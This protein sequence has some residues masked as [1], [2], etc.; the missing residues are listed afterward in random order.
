[1]AVSAAACFLSDQSFGL[2]R[3]GCRAAECTARHFQCAAHAIHSGE[4]HL[5]LGLMSVRQ[6]YAVG[7]RVANLKGAISPY[8]LHTYLAPLPLRHHTADHRSA[9][10]AGTKSRGV[11]VCAAQR[12]SGSFKNT[13][14]SRSRLVKDELPAI[15]SEL[16]PT[17]NSNLDT[18]KLVCGS[19]KT[20]WWL[21]RNEDGRPDGCQHKHAWQ[22]RII[23]RCRHHDP[24]GCP[25]C[26]GERVCPCNSLAAGQFPALMHC[27]DSERTAWWLDPTQLSPRSSVEVCWRHDCGDGKVHHWSASVCSVVDAYRADGQLPCPGCRRVRRE[28][29][30]LLKDELPDIYAELHPTKNSDIDTEKLTCGSSKRVWWLCKSDKRRP[31]GCQHEHAWETQVSSRC[32]EHNP[33]GCPFCAGVRIC[34][35]KS[36]AERFPALLH[37]WDSSRLDPTQHGP[38]SQKWISWRHDCGDGQIH[39]WGAPIVNVVASFK[40]NGQVPCPR[41]RSRYDRRYRAAAAAR[42]TK[43][44]EERKRYIKHE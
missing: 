22:A 43:G 10:L 17:E 1:M 29:G 39:R 14:A 11:P 37:C 21:C 13:G 30:V 38:H 15:Y 4:E 5:V 25:F 7:W 36:L 19:M 41:C 24:P 20:V 26:A 2:E 33:R 34:P 35:C 32:T 44:V 6:T 16:H 27:W 31:E 42:T 18:E 9:V 3:R 40:A 12:E 23:S 28:R 8:C